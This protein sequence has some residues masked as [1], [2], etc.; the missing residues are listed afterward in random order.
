MNLKRKREDL[1]R[2]TSLK[3]ISTLNNQK[4][5]ES[6]IHSF[7]SSHKTRPIIFKYGQFLGGFDELK[8]DI[9]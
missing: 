4:N 1:S 7:N 5:N 3:N 9:K 2:N 8:K 6:N